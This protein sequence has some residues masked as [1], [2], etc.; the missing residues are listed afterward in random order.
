VTAFWRDR[1]ISPEWM[2]QDVILERFTEDVRALRCPHYR[3]WLNVDA[4]RRHG[5]CELPEA[6]QSDYRRKDEA[7]IL[8]SAADPLEG[9]CCPIRH[10]FGGGHEAWEILAAKLDAE[11]HATGS[12]A[13]AVE[14][15]KPKGGPKNVQ[16]ARKWVRAYRYLRTVRGYS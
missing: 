3:L 15:V 6:A 11:E 8:D 7:I 14:R 2:V 10:R 4:L 5:C 13:V 12:Y 9:R 16:T 1:G